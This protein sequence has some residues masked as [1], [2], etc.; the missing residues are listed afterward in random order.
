MTRR[1]RVETV[2]RAH[3]IHDI[4]VHPMAGCG[5]N[6]VPKQLIA[7]LLT[8]LE[9][10]RNWEALRDL[11]AKYVYVAPG[12]LNK[13]TDEVLSWARGEGEAARPWCEHLKQ[14]SNPSQPGGIDYDFLPHYSSTTIAW[15]ACPMCGKPRPAP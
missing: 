12:L 2:L 4:C 13:A 9:P 14:I 1:E 5:C 7:D 6:P 3:G 15:M 10:E 11:L 8:A